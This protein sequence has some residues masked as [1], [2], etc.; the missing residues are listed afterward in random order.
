M[1]PIYSTKN[2]AKKVAHD[3]ER[4][5]KVNMVGVEKDITIL[6][7]IS[8]KIKSFGELYQKLLN[9]VNEMQADLFGGIGFDDEEWISFEVP[10][11]LMDL[12]NSTDPGYFFGEDERNPLK[13]YKY[14]GLKALLNHPRLKEQYRCMVSQDKFVPNTVA[15]NNFLQR[16]SVARTKLA[17]AT[18]ISMGGPAQGTEY[19]S[20][21]L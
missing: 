5:D 9:E 19:T 7:R 10:N 2:L 14:L 12:I 18:H 21:Y 1:S 13:K 3:Q 17:V 15:C 11:P 8:V 4:N 20:Q 6:G 16:A